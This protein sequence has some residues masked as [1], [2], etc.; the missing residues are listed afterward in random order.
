MF[1]SKTG[2]SCPLLIAIINF[3]LPLAVLFG[4]FYFDG[5]TSFNIVSLAWL[6]SV[7]VASSAMFVFK[8]SR[9]VQTGAVGSLA[10]CGVALVCALFLAALD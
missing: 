2:E 7:M 10:G 8:E 4:W 9:I 1:K 5:S 6:L 3:L